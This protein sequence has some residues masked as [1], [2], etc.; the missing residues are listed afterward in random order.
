MPAKINLIG[1]K[2]G[3]LTVIKETEERKNKSIVW[4]CKC[5]CGQQEKFSTK[6][7]RSDGIVQCHCCGNQRK[8][9]SNLL[10][11]I[12]GKKFNSLL[13]LEKTE[14][15]AGGKIL[16]KCKCDCGNITYVNRTDLQKSHIKSCGCIRLKYK[17][18]DIINNKQIIAL[19]GYEQHNK[20]SRNHN[21][22][23]RC[24]CLLCGREYDAAGQTLDKSPGCGC[25]KSV[26]GN[27][28]RQILEDN[29]IP[30]IKEYSF[31]NSLYRFDFAILD[32]NKIIRL[33]EFD[34]EQHFPENIKETGWNTLQHYLQTNKRDKIKNNLALQN[35][36]PLVRIP[37][38]ERYN[39][40]LDML[41]RDNIFLVS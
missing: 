27:N 39:I 33:I 38:W 37:Y 15:K 3:K 17:V 36:I 2:F 29:K 25:L 8:P 12:V 1:Q 31:P 35:N 28:I 10:E 7:L 24:K 4:V 30:Y 6:E 16:Y 26:G 21:H 34:G 18:G 41:L 20:I 13:V 11:D 9:N 19:N 40:T 14:K 22:Y 23:Y 32:N 5:D